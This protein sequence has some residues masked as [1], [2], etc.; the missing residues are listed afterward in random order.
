MRTNFMLPLQNVRALCVLLLSALSAPVLAAGQGSAGATT[1][2]NVDVTLTT[3]ISARL[4]GLT[5][6][7]LGTWTGTGDL[8]ANQD[9]CVGRT[10]AGFF[11]NGSYRVRASGSGDASNIHAFTLSNGVQQIY[12]DV[13]FNDQTGVAGR[14]PLTGGVMLSAQQGLGIWE[15]FN[16]LFGCV[17]RNGNLSIGVPEAALSA[18]SGGLYTGTLTLVLIPD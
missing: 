8:T 18:A 13:F 1:S 9:L 3:G 4:S 14:T 16:V 10:G 5:D 15:I 12:Y 6:F 17:V 7:A 11:A 2:G